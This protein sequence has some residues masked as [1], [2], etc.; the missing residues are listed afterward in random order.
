MADGVAGGR[1]H[2]DVAIAPRGTNALLAGARVQ[3]SNF[4]DPA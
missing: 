3:V 1:A 4:W 2:P